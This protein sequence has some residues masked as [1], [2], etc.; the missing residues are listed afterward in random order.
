MNWVAA[1][2]LKDTQAQT[3]DI[4]ELF[5]KKVTDP[6]KKKQHCTSVTV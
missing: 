3:E 1:Q 5:K 6:W 2:E 4:V